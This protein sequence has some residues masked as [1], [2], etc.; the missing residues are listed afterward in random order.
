MQ[1]LGEEQEKLLEARRGIVA[2]LER[3]DPGVSGGGIDDEEMYVE[4]A[5][6][7]GLSEEDVR[8]LG[9]EDLSEQLLRESEQMQ[10]LVQLLEQG[11]S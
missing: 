2:L 6:G 8:G 7:G 10:E 5:D 1:D 3:E 9:E 11:E 4:S